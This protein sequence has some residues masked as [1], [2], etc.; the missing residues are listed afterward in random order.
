[1]VERDKPI[2]VAVL[3]GLAAIKPGAKLTPE[4]LDVWWA[5]MRGWSLTEFREAAAHLAKTVEFMPNPF[6]FERVR[7]AGE[8]T[9]AEAWSLVLANVRR[10]EYRN[11]ISVGERADRVVRA[12]GGYH[13]L[14]MSST[15]DL[16]FREKRFAELW[17]Q[18]ADVEEARTA[19]PS[20]AAPKAEPALYNASGPKAIG[21]LLNNLEK[22][23]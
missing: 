8:H 21:E 13:V 19:V 2:F 7:K 20:L 3:N 4:A 18:L 15:A 10:G 6:H 1:M 16:H 9:A 12:M 22:P 14:G 17:D 5:A 11:G 23:R